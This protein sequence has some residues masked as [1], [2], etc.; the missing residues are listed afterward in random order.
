MSNDQIIER[1]R[2]FQLEGKI[3]AFSVSRKEGEKPKIWLSRIESPTEDLADFINSHEGTE[4]QQ[5]GQDY[6]FFFNDELRPGS[7]LIR[8]SGGKSEGPGGTL[9]CLLTSKDGQEL[10]FLAAGHVLT[11]FWRDTKGQGSIYRYRKG[12]PSTGSSRFLGKVL[13]LPHADQLPKPIH[14]NERTPSCWK[15]A[16]LDVGAVRLDVDLKEVELK[17]RTTC[18]GGFGEDPID[19][20]EGMRV[21][22]CGSQEAH[23]TEAVVKVSGCADVTIFGPDGSKYMFC[24]QIILRDLDPHDRSEK[25][26]KVCPTPQ[27]GTPF[28]VPGDSG[29]IVVDVATK[30]PVGML[31]AGSVLDRLYVVTPFE[32]IK[33]FFDGIGLVRQRA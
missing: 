20:T 18:F 4:A 24:D 17:Q 33:A 6:Y 32:K 8:V 14:K 25:K 21:V 19:A 22:K 1:L 27:H 2:S 13:Y 29:T 9:T 23:C 5:Q 11:D 3:T 12:Y 15:R 7:G 30:R 10:Y 26:C 28:A 16:S 31:I